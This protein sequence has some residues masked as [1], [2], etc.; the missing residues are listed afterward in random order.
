MPLVTNG[1]TALELLIAL[2]VTAV[3]AALAVPSLSQFANE[4]RLAATMAQLTADLNFARTEAIK[5][6]ARVLVCARAAGTNAC[7]TQ[8]DWQNGWVVCFDGNSDD[9]CDASAAQD[10]NPLRRAGAVHPRLRLAGSTSL[11]RFNAVGS[12][13]GG[14]TLT[15]TGDWTGSSV[16]TG[17]VATTGVVASRKN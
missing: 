17:S 2:A 14:A 13:N 1:F 16:R 7:S 15:L 9:A 8:P 12:S 5:R 10:P 4:Q 11:V 6:N 3:L